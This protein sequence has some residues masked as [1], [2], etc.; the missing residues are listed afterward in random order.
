MDP[1]DPQTVFIESQGGRANRVNLATL[2]HQAIAP[3][4]AEKPPARGGGEEGDAGLRWNWDTPMTMSS[5]DP[6]VL[7]MGAN[8]VFRSADRGVTWKAI[9]PDLTA[10]IDRT[11]LEMMGQRVT[12]RT[13]SR[14]DGQSNYGTLTTIGESPLDRNLLYTGSDDGQL[15]TT[16]DGG[17]HWTNITSKVP[18]LPANTYVSS[19]LPSR[20]VAGRVYATF[21]GHFNDDYRPY[22]FVSEDY[23]QSWKAISAGLPETGTHRL[24]EDLKDPRLLFLGHEK[25]L[26]VSLDGG[27]SWVALNVGMPRVPVDDLLI[28]P[29]THDLV[30]GTHGRSIWIVDDI[31]PIEALTPEVLTSAAAVLPSSRA[32]LLRIYNPQAWYGAGQYFAPNP[33]FGGVVTYY[34][35]DA[36]AGEVEIDIT[37]AA[38]KSVRVLHGPGRRGLN[39][40]TWDLR[41]EPPVKEEREAPGVGGFGGA[42]SG[43]EVL[44]GKYKIA[45]KLPG[46]GS[47]SVGEIA[48]EGDPR[49][50]FSDGDRR[51]RQSSLLALYDLEQALGP[52][53]SS[54]RALTAQLTAIT[55]DLAPAGGG[56]RGAPGGESSRAPL[57]N[58]SAAAAQVQADVERQLNGA[59]QLARAIEG[60]SGV[61]TEISDG[62]STGPM[63]MRPPRSRP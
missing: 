56:R 3:V 10:A 33:D 19:V 12:D 1:S 60:Y 36:I 34:L 46:S 50:P 37:D 21:D 38:G 23:G 61:P 62:E 16:R 5:G 51:T 39:R 13:L 31:G 41:L 45:L 49:T 6:A 17:A 29:R 59:S 47:P 54:A 55:R 20:F 8:R 15:Q 57:D 26:H 28:H 44:P 53:R 25:G 52:A 9:S 30:I 11:K 7:Y 58:V 24:R 22:V 40:L 48:V 2:E 18:G 4:G 42:P 27:A 35:K 63:R 14:N 43:P 32:Q